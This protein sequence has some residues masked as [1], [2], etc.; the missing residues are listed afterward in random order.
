MTES[1]AWTAISDRAIWLY[2]E[3]KKRFEFSTGYSRLILPYSKISWRMSRGSYFVAMRELRDFGFIKV[4]EQGGL[5]HKPSVYCL[6]EEWRQISVKI[7]DSEG[8]EAIKRGLAKKRA[9]KDHLENLQGK[10]EWE[11]VRDRE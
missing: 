9:H 5:Y 11:R 2:I 8:R 6:S 3:L 7:M 10:R 1:A 4:V